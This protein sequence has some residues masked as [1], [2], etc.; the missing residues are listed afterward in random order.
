MS[1]VQAP[2]RPPR[3]RRR[4]RT[5][6]A[7]KT[8]ARTARSNVRRAPVDVA[9]SRRRTRLRRSVAALAVAV[10]VAGGGTGA[11]AGYDAAK[12]HGLLAVR[13]IA[14][15]GQARL[16]EALLLER[17]GPLVGTDLP[18]VDV[19]AVSEA[20]LSHP[21]I[22]RVAVRR[23]YPGTLWVRVWERRPAAL[24]TPPSGGDGVMVDLE[25]VVLGPPEPWQD[26]DLPRLTGIDVRRKV[27]GDRVDAARVALG[28]AV[29]RAWGPD[30]LVDVA[31][32]EDPLLLVEALR[33]RLGAGGGYPWRLDRLSALRPEILALAGRNGAEVDLRYDDRV[34]ARPL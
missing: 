28:V 21:W 8:A 20:L 11:W 15:E 7:S 30:A 26:G 25:G 14:L 13:Q 4:P 16:P 6:A 34:I 27:A 31:D 12:D 10:L 24:V 19:D 29:A 22:E 18:D 23:M 33:V 3:A 17:I 32:P 2:P 9:R 5:A 1:R